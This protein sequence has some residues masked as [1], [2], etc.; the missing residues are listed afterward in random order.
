MRG[1]YAVPLS[2]T[3][4]LIRGI[5][6]DITVFKLYERRF[7]TEIPESIQRRYDNAIRQLREIRSGTISLDIDIPAADTGY[8][9]GNKTSSDREFSK[10]VLNG[11]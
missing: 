8:Y 11:L 7:V 3:P 1:R 5:S 9:A 6:V 10:A 4:G 2:P